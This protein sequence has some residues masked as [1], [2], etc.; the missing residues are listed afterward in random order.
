MRRCTEKKVYLINFFHRSMFDTS[1]FRRNGNDDDDDD[2]A[3]DR[4]CL[5]RVPCLLDGNNAPAHMHASALR[6]FIFCL[7]IK[8][9]TLVSTCSLRATHKEPKCNWEEYI[10]YSMLC[11][12]VSRAGPTIRAT[13]TLAKSAQATLHCWMA[14]REFWCGTEK[15]MKKRNEHTVI[16]YDKFS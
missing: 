9:G 7:E 12:V 8:L 4:R 10:F 16:D 11:C 5:A 1:T 3:A 2:D 13:A 6:V 14:Q 15:G